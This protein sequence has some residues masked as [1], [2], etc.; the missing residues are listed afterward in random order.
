MSSR[1]C[2]NRISLRQCYQYSLDA[3]RLLALGWGDLTSWHPM[4]SQDN[5]LTADKH[6]WKVT[7]LGS[8][9]NP[10]ENYNHMLSKVPIIMQP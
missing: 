3:L 6:A 4:R 7:N 9:Y 10:V 5:L 2:G 8:W 1:G